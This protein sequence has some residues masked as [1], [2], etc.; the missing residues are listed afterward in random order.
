[1]TA[2]AGFSPM[3]RLF[4]QVMDND[5]RGLKAGLWVFAALVFLRGG[6]G[7][8]CVFNGAYVAS[9]ADGIPMDS[10][11]PAAARI[12][13]TDFATWGLMQVMLCLIAILALARYRAMVPLMVAIFLLEH[14]S[15]KLIL[16]TMPIVK[17]GDAPGSYVNLA[18]FGLEVAGLILA[19]WPRGGRARS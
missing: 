3:R 2:V 15:R 12:I 6:I 5:Y 7:L 11:T 18:I 4:P 19:L 13:A 14:A 16:Y 1:M 10:F 9:H 17:T 8:N